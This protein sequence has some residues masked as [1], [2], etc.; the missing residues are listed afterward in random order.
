MC[1]DDQRKTLKRR[2][3]QILKRIKKLKKQKEVE[4]LENNIEHIKS[5]QN[6]ARRMY[7]AIRTL[8]KRSQN[9]VIVHNPDGEFVT[10]PEQKVNIITDFFENLFCVEN[11]TPFDDI[12]PVKLSTPFTS[13]EIRKAANK[14]RNGK[15]TGSD[16]LPAELVKAGPSEL[17]EE[18]ATVLNIAAEN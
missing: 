3:N 1:N 5:C 6:D 13:E 2:R 18:I 12:P 11:I 4:K 17:H 7:E 8:N 14:L 9:T 15:S 10:S 16:N